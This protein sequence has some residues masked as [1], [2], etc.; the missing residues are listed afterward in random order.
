MRISTNPPG[1]TV[2]VQGKIA[3]LQDSNNRLAR[4][5]DEKKKRE[6]TL[7]EEEV[8][9]DHDRHRAQA[10]PIEYEFHSVG[11]GYSIYCQKRGYQ[12]LYQVEKVKTKWYE[13]PIIDFF[14]DCLPFTVTDTREFE[15]NLAPA[16]AA[17]PQEPNGP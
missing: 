15:Y 5:I 17:R 1:A 9:F 4:K 16:S 14:V 6:S 2:Y 13:L 11:C 3:T 7:S 12:P 10:T 8:R